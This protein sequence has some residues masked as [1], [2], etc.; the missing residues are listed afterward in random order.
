MTQRNFK[1]TMRS[2]LIYLLLICAFLFTT[3]YNVASDVPVVPSATATVGATKDTGGNVSLGA[4]EAGK[5][6]GKEAGG[7]DKAATVVV[8]LPKNATTTMSPEKNA[9]EQEHYSSM[10]IFFVLCVI[11]LGILLIH[12]MLQTKFQY[13]PESIVVVF[14]G[15]LIGLILNNSSMRHI[16]NWE[17]EEVFSPTAFFLVLLPPIIFESGYN[18]HKG[19]FFQNIGSIL[20][21]AIIGTTISAL[22]I[23]SG[24]YL[25]GLAEV[26]Y[27][28]NFVES[29]AFGSLISAVDPVATVAIFHAL[30]VDPI[31]NMLVFGESILNDAISIVLTTTVMPMVSGSGAEGN[32]ESII[33]ALNTFCLMFF[34]SA[35]IGV[36]FALMSAL[37]L[38]HIDLRKHPSLE[39]GLM[40]V[41]TYAPYV[42]AEGIH[43]SGIMAILFCGIVMSHYTHFNLSTVTQITMQQT[44]RTL[45]F[46][47]ETCVF[48]YL[49]LAIF[50]FKHRCEL[51]FVIWTII[52]CLLGRAANIFPL[53]YVCNLFRE[54]KIT[55]K[56][57]FILWF[58][59]LRGAISY[60]LSLHMQFSSE[61]ARHVVITT[62]LIIVLFTTLFFGG[63][64]M[65]LMKYLAGGKKTRRRPSRLGGRKRSGKT[66]S[67]SKTREWGQAIDSEHLSELTEEEEVSFTQSK[68]NGFARLDRKYFTPFFTRRFTHQEL[69]DCKSQMADLTNKWYQAIRISPDDLDEE[70]DE[71]DD[72][73]EVASIA[74][75]ERSTR[76]LVGGGRGS[77]SAP[78]K[79]TAERPGP[80]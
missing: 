76:V 15:A 64:T 2:G 8:V 38:K 17:R 74:T 34:A 31:L 21:F 23:G 12:M 4:V 71:D 65:P 16:A 68:L 18:L 73:A 53:A 7:E 42:L 27:R 57:S 59:G 50:S 51:S 78:A 46:I 37:L 6:K 63:S 79:G 24:V 9:V 66:L 56:M 14:L 13:L 75:S 52:L 69:H 44:M 70:E 40:L 62:T 32:G 5:D 72:A 41:F 11:A 54:H 61:E 47:A 35:G 28:L 22:V 36:L 19:N 39:F 1:A 3:F 33:S 25:L 67:L 45:A 43:L 20:V 58:S 48:A 10:S 49:G 77:K 30:D 29:F 26:A 55:P 80:S 60:A